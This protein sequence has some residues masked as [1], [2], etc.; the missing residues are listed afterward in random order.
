MNP[1]A[2]WPQTCARDRHRMAE[3]HAEVLAKAG[4]R[5]APLMAGD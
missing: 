3:T 1:A 5:G 4:A 2:G